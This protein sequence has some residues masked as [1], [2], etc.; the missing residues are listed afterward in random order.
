MGYLSVRGGSVRGWGL[1]RSGG[2]AGQVSVMS[3]LGVQSDRQYG[4]VVSQDRNGWEGDGGATWLKG[5]CHR[6]VVRWHTSLAGWLAGGEDEWWWLWFADG[7]KNQRCWIFFFLYGWVHGSACLTFCGLVVGWATVGLLD[8][9]IWVKAW[10]SEFSL[11]PS[12]C[13]TTMEK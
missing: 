1:M 10:G 11:I 5:S 4:L 2:G 6:R 7:Q 12:W 9:G 8:V 13:R 3:S